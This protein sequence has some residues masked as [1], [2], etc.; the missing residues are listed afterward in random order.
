MATK[1]EAEFSQKK[2]FLVAFLNFSVH[3]SM[4]HHNK[5]VFPA[6][7]VLDRIKLERLT[8]SILFWRGREPTRMN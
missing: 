7:F 5:T 3:Q 4:T 8:I 2:K 6:R 1:N